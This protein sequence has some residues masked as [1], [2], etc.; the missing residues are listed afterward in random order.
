MRSMDAL[1]DH[2][3]AV[4]AAVEG[5]LRPL[6]DHDPSVVFFELATISTEGITTL[7]D[8]VREFHIA[9]R[10]LS[11]ASSFRVVQTTDGLPTYHDVFA[12]NAAETKT[13]LPTLT[14]VLACSPRAT[15]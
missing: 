10:A 14:A 7:T 4:D 1:M 3:A 5:L 11:R 13:L 8:D 9:R 15:C 12:G 6:I 2:L